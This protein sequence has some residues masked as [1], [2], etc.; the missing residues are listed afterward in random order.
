MNLTFEEIYII[1]QELSKIVCPV[2]HRLVTVD[3]SINKV[4]YNECC[5][6]VGK[7]CK[8]VIVE[9]FASIELDK[10]TK[11]LGF[12]KR[13]ENFNDRLTFNNCMLF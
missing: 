11:A 13:S 9:T 4:N 3:Y 8:D 7:L 2:H 10:I 6:E 5:E 12:D 1:N